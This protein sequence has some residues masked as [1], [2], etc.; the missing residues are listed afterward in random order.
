ML[1]PISKGLIFGFLIAAPIGPIGIL[2]I[3][4]TLTNGI[5]SGFI[6]GLG[7][8]TADG[9]YGLIAIFGV[10][11]LTQYLF[12][13]QV[14]LQI[15]AGII[16]LLLGL[17]FLISTS[18][19][20]IGNITHPNYKIDY[21]STLGLT[22]MNPMTIL[23]FGAVFTGLEFNLLSND[24]S[25]GLLLVVGVF[26]GSV[27]WWF[28]LALLTRFVRIKLFTKNHYLW[29]NRLS[30]VIIVGFAVM[31]LVT[32]F[33]STGKPVSSTL[34]SGSIKEVI[35]GSSLGYTRAMPG[36]PLNFPADY[37]PHPDFQTEWWYYTGNLVDGD[38]HRFGY[39]LT[40]F[41]RS[42]IPVQ[43]YKERVSKWGT[44][45]VY[46]GHFALTDVAK[47]KHYSHEIIDRGAAEI[48]GSQSDPFT[49][50]L[51]S[52]QVTQTGPETY[53]LEADTWLDD[54][55]RL[56]IELDLEN[57]KGL[58]LHGDQGYSRKGSEEGNASFYY[59]MTR[60]VSVG[61]ISIGGNTYFVEG[62]SWMDHEFSTSAL[63]LDQI[64]WDWFSIQLDNGSEL[65]VFQ[66]RRKDGSVD[67]YSSGTWI[68]SDNQV[69][70]LVKNDFSIEIMDHWKSD[71]S[72][73]NYPSRWVINVE[74][75]NLHI[76]L[77]PLVPD[78]EMNLTY[79]YW[80]G[81]VKVRGV[82]GEDQFNGFGYVELT[83]YA[84]TM[85]GEF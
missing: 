70:K 17:R 64:G 44:Q 50:W 26:T 12:A 51:K 48:A 34:T 43:E 57:A 19:A 35:P 47:G 25:Q 81:A 60:L 58:T 56:Q 73:G 39:Q 79:T 37:G 1:T 36:V 40:L 20:E 66:I 65:M 10:G 54:G 3:K 67:P 2:C 41:R 80:E 82:N 33:S 30:G 21:F 85:A 5:L 23:S 16:L 28:L 69:V 22:L 13:W 78:Q 4:R 9:I 14:W 55:S 76:E 49:V 83:G 27:I 71:N 62:L 38:G 46:L 32:A 24:F 72:G 42:L 53:I 63:S 31:V 52:W 59:S 75:I 6:S 68:S 15:S 61:E 84:G 11:V 8:A 45:S 77:E 18:K 7:A 29:I 74:K